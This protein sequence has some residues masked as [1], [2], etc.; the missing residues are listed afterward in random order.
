MYKK[1]NDLVTI[2]CNNLNTIQWI[3]EVDMGRSKGD[4]SSTSSVEGKNKWT[5]TFNSLYAFMACI[6]TTL[7]P[8]I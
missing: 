2:H 5:H 6:G 8:H 1:K 7:L 3:S 4:H